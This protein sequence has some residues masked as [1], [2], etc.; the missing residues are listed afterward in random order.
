MGY[1][2]IQILDSD[3]NF[4]G[5][6]NLNYDTSLS[7]PAS[8]KTFEKVINSNDEKGIIVGGFTVRKDTIIN[9]IDSLARLDTSLI[10]HYVLTILKIDSTNQIGW[11]RYY[12]IRNGYDHGLLHDI[13]SFLAADILLARSHLMEKLTKNLKNPTSCPGFF[14]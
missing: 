7:T 4:M 11:K 3:F 2:I 6:I 8:L 10:T 14:E 13:K 5:Y 12:R 1:G 9:Y